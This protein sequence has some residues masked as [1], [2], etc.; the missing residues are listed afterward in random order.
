MNTEQK[1]SIKSTILECR[2]I[3]EEDIEQALI[4]YG[5]YVNK[6]WVNMRDLKN[7]SEEEE[8]K[9]KGIEAVIEKLQKG[10]FNKSKA[11]VEYIK[12]VAYTYLNRLA[13]LRVMEVRG[14]IDE[15]LISRDKY[16]NKSFIGSRFYE[17]AREFCKFEIDG[18][19][20]YL[21]NIMFEEVS[22]EIKMLF[23]TEDEYSF[24][25][26]SSTNLLK[27]IDLL[28]TNI[29]EESWRQ[30]EII[31]WIYQYFNEKEKEDVFN[32]LYNAKQKIKV[33]DIP[34]ATQLFTPDWIV[35]WIVDN[36]LGSL[37]NEIKKGKE[38]GKKIEEIKLLDPCCGSGH[39]LVK[40]YDLFYKM[41]LEEGIYCEEEIPYKILQNNIYGIDIDLRA[42]QLTGLI[43]FIKTKTYLKESNYEL[44][45]KEKISVN[46][47]CADVIL[48]NG[49]RLRELKERHKQNKT[50]LKMIDII[51]EEF[52][53]VRIKGSLIQPEKRLFP[54]FEEYKNRI[55]KSELNTA[56][57]VKKKQS[58]GQKSLLG[59][60]SISFSEYKT[61]RGFTKEEKELIDSL[62][63]I[64]S[65]AI[66]ANDIS[67]QLFANEAV[68][69][70]K[71]VDIFMKQ[72][73]VVVTNPP[74]ISKNGYD[75]NLNDFLKTNYKGYDLNLYCPFI[76][77]IIDFTKEKG[78]CGSITLDSFMFLGSYEKIRT[79]ILD[80]TSI[81]KMVHLG[82]KA[83]DDISGEKV[84]TA[85]FVLKKQL[86]SKKASN[87]IFY[88][89]DDIT[90]SL[91]KKKTLY[92]ENKRYLCD[93]SIFK[94]IKGFPFIYWIKKEI[95]D[96]LIKEVKI[97]KYIS[98][99]TG[100]NTGNNARFL[101]F[102]WEIQDNL[103]KYK[104]YVKGG[105]S[106]QYIGINNVKILWDEEE[107][108]K[109]HGSAIRN[110]Q[111]YF[112]EG[113]TFSGVNSKRFSVRYLPKGY[114][115]DSGGSFIH[116]KDSNDILY[117]L[118]L[119]NSKT[120]NYIL[121]LLNPTIN[122]K[123]GD[124]HRI[125]YMKPSKEQKSIIEKCVTNIIELKNKINENNELD[126]NFILPAILK[127]KRE[128]IKQSIMEVTN[129]FDDY[130][131]EIEKN[132]DIIDR[133]VFEIYGLSQ[134]VI[135]DIK[136]ISGNFLS[137]NNKNID[138]E[139]LDKKLS[140]GTNI[141]EIC[142]DNEYNILEI[143]KYKEDNLENKFINSE[144]MV[145]DLISYY[146]GCLFGRFENSFI[147][148]VS[149]GILPIGSS[150][151][152][153]EDLIEKIYN[154]IQ[155]S[156][157][158]EIADYIFEEIEMILN[159]SLEEYITNSFFNEH[160]KKYYI[161]PQKRPIYWHIC[162][163]KKT[164][165]C[166]IYYHKLDNDTLYKVKS[167]YL[168]QMIDRYQEDLKYYADQ[169]IEVRTNGDKSREKDLKDKCSDLEIKLEDLN[170]LDK[171]IMEI[172][173]YKPDV[174]QGVLY[175]I[176]PLES[177]LSITVPTKKERE[178][179][180]KEVDK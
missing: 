61:K 44:N 79:K 147:D 14:L 29:D 150:I 51:Y 176:I 4:N 54:L 175:N 89:L 161:K 138:F 96:L 17:T 19:L 113:L 134:D 12:E 43:L 85:M 16:G 159:Q 8:K 170:E 135:D 151:F 7:L 98:A 93:T 121:R 39:F 31:G 95:S 114:I 56:K 67:K 34:A 144:K 35:K 142:E 92:N 71:L 90:D 124:I 68:K 11:I 3:L 122:F 74:Y 123:N 160:S 53:D 133:T 118:G 108:R 139:L 140:E 21:L 141:T 26:P 88:K 149:D 106:V 82:T 1:K 171:K 33:E 47:V 180:Y 58:K 62:N 60:E 130:L 178:N 13:A 6:D 20:S 120:I 145:N 152:A 126:N 72:Y 165:N 37:W 99:K 157:S 103:D 109:T 105:G 15:I 83:F 87:S 86:T 111:Y 100:M 24:V 116:I 136:D 48:L 27:I 173:P 91:K 30:D 63:V 102:C 154:C 66:K 69:S 18:G 78:Y 5:I 110:K 158:D 94:E 23:N 97:S 168:S 10:G 25:S 129:K 155:N 40:A 80:N 104:N 166:F 9:R 177:I 64:Y 174:S 81:Y 143:K 101:R 119:L 55:V 77:R 52:E 84:S 2:N 125:P 117:F 75:S 38:E 49:S 115:F 131:I 148:P 169:L 137:D 172:L 107:I 28:C 128:S 164:F 146:I 57:R 73:D 156:Y 50:I 127:F 41:Y 112:M 70:V 132:K 36:S 42:V 153:E 65:E 179:Y 59:E 22:T 32:R 45:A 163:P 162:S 46:L 167:I 76:D